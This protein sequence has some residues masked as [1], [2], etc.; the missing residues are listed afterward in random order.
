MEGG[1]DGRIKSDTLFKPCYP[2]V[3]EFDDEMYNC[4][5]NSTVVLSWKSPN[6]E[7]RDS[8]RA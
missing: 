3:D 1:R 8:S 6:S 7:Y 2:V 5:Y 4:V